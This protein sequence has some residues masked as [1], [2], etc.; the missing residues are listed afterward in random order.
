MYFEGTTLNPCLKCLPFLM[1]SK[2]PK[3]LFFISYFTEVFF[4]YFVFSQI[5]NQFPLVENTVLN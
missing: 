1:L 2:L 3:C 5:H 4:S